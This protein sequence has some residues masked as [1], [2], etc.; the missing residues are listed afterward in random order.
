MIIQ[1]QLKNIASCQ[2]YTKDSSNNPIKIQSIINQ[3][4]EIIVRMCSC[5]FTNEHFTNG[6][7]R[8]FDESPTT[9]TFRTQI[10]RTIQT[11]S[12]ELVPYI[13]QWIESTEGLVVNGLYLVLVKDCP[14]VIESF[15]SSVC[16]GTQETRHDD[17]TGG[18][19]GGIIGGLVAILI[20][21]AVTIIVTCLIFKYK[22]KRRRQIE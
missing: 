13:E 21:V 3:L 10:S 2:D 6:F 5:E 12:S 4:T 15:D 19:V 17:R 7:L 9:V 18:L 8:C 11:S 1:I 22:S 20:A 16:Q 14:L